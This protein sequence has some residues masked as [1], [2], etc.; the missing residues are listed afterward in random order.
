MSFWVVLVLMS[1]GQF[2]AFPLT[3]PMTK[4]DC[5]EVALKI[6]EPVIDR[7]KAVGCILNSGKET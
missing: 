5:Q 6:I 2:H 7:V 4:S 1:S 3:Q